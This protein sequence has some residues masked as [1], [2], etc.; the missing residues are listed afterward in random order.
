M[1]GDLSDSVKGRCIEINSTEQYAAI[2]FKDGTV[3]VF[4]FIESA[5]S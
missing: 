1:T 4:T 3:R 2:G 5:P